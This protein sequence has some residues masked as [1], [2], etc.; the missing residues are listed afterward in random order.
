MRNQSKP[1]NR[2]P[3]NRTRVVLDESEI[4][5]RLSRPKRPT[6]AECYA[7]E[8]DLAERSRFYS[9]GP[10]YI[11]PRPNPRPRPRPAPT[12]WVT[13][14]ILKARGWTDTAIRDF[15]PEPESH[16]G[17]P[18]PQARRRMPLWRAATVAE[19][20]SDPAWQYWLRRSLARRRVTLDDLLDPSN[21]RAF[22]QRAGKAAAAIAAHRRTRV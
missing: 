6:L 16:C 13:R 11:A 19:A 2:K 5:R 10:T 22:L 21:D 15:L 14:P 9:E 18:H 4:Q 20:E 17:N 1:R 3:H 7:R 8:T 12:I